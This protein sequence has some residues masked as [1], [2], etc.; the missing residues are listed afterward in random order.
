M[1]TFNEKTGMNAE[2]KEYYRLKGKVEAVEGYVNSTSFPSVKDICAILGVE[3]KNEGGKE[4][5][6][7]R[8]D[9]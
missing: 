4:D 3:M 2:V 5:E 8:N 9:Q 1:G 7:K 6:R